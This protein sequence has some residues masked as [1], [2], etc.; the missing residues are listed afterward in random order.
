[1]N[2]SHFLHIYQPAEQ[3]QDILERV[4]HE[5][6]RPLVE[7]LRA[8]PSAK[9]TIN[10]NGALTDLLFERGFRDIIEGLKYLAERGQI[11]FTGSAK[12]H[13]FLPL[14]PEEEV[15][16]QIRINTETNRDYFGAVFSP[17]G[18]FAPE[19]A[20]SG[21]IRD[22]IQ[23]LGY[24]WII[25]DEI[26]YSG[27]NNECNFTKLSAIQGSSVLAVFRERKTSNIIMSAVVR[28]AE[29]LKEILKD[30]QKKDRYILTA[31]DGE[32]FGHHRPGHHQIL[33]E[34]LREPSFSSTTVSEM[35]QLFPQG[36][37]VEPKEST[38]ASSEDNLKNN[39]QFFSWKDPENIIHQWQWEFL[40]FV[41]DHFRKGAVAESS[42]LRKK[43][44]EALAS[45][46]YWWASAKPW[47]S[48]E[49]IERGAWG[50]FELLQAIPGITEENVSVAHEYYSK[51]VLKAF[52]WQRT[53]YI[54]KL[55]QNYQTKIKI[56]FK[57]RTVGEGKPE[58]FDAFIEFMEQ[59]MKESAE[60]RNF[61]RAILWRDAIWKLHT[62]N[63][64]YDA[65]HA[66]DL[67]RTEVT[68]EDLRKL[69]DEYKER[70]ARI[71]GGQPEQR[72]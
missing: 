21:V 25:L 37:L 27:H 62:K 61:E 71:K 13:A 7:G 34:I 67:L 12:Y 65:I 48:I 31:M 14:L 29:S 1:M 46:Q 5:S 11:E 8:N 51:I 56:P 4:V 66:T 57:D 58:V 42:E 36:G 20:Y 72:M 40:Y 23:R 70:Y 45:D 18:F 59:K 41:M 9:I 28:S 26:A 16:R 69:M 47:W 3:R 24:Q 53:G 50:L 2:L 30:E 68:D 17:H 54:L 52:E 19:M 6:Y 43:M 60:S 32:T 55:A 10:I 35:I 22:V 64:I 49:M 15:E 38:W 39:T 33:F 44:D 63:D